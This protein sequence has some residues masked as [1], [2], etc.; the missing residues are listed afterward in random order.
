VLSK[1]FQYKNER[2]ISLEKF[3]ANVQLLFSEYSD[4]DEAFSSIGRVEA[5]PRKCSTGTWRIP[6]IHFRFIATW[7]LNLVAILI[8]IAFLPKRPILQI[9]ANGV[10]SHNKNE[11]APLH[12]VQGADERVS[13]LL[14]QLPLIVLDDNQAAFDEQ[15]RL[16]TTPKKRCRGRVGGRDRNASSV[17]AGKKAVTKLAK[18]ISALTTRVQDVEKK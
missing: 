11:G 5:C 8:V 1:N 2:A 16:N 9:E 7:T 17:K 6:R 4:N 13:P 3:L 10:A 14:Q 18:Q 12:G 15:K